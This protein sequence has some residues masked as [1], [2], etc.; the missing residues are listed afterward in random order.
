MKQLRS[1][2]VAQLTYVV[3]RPIAVKYEKAIYDMS[4]R[5]DRDYT[6]LAYE[7]VGQ[8][9][10]ANTKTDRLSIL[11]DINNNVDGFDSCVYGECYTNYAERL[12]KTQ[13]KPKAVKGMY[14]CK[15]KGCGSDEFYVWSQQTRGGDEGMT[16]FRQC[17]KCGKR[18]KE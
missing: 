15:E 12:N 18:G 11:K 14:K 5:S 13:E 17:Q 16:I 7:K 6:S 10:N 3:D 4:M 1:K 2:V 9:Q 8:L